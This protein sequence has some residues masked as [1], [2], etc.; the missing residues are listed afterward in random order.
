M[1]FYLFNIRKINIIKLFLLFI[2]QEIIYLYII[3]YT[4]FHSFHILCLEY[5]E[6]FN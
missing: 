5:F 2:Y 3:S 6:N 4:Y 1:L